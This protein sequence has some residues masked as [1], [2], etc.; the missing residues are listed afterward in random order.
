MYWIKNNNEITKGYENQSGFRGFVNYKELKAKA[1]KDK[2]K[3]EDL[4]KEAGVFSWIKTTKAIKKGSL[5][6]LNF[7]RY[8]TESEVKEAGGELFQAE[9]LSDLNPKK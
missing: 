8:A 4:L 7:E 6:T 9:I 3:V 5:H 2:V 1:D